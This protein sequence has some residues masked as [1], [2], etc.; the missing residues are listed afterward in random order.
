MQKFFRKQALLFSIRSSWLCK[1]ALAWRGAE[2]QFFFNFK[3]W[4]LY[5]FNK[6][7]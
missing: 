3:I 4:L 1:N 6:P 2:D 5:P 7:S